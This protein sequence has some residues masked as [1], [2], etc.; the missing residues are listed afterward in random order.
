[1][2]K[3]ERLKRGDKVAV[4]SLS[5][6]GLGDKE[7]I[8]KYY[9]AK[10]R[11]KNIFGLELIPT[12]NA[13]KGTEFIYNH[14][15]LRAKDWMDAFRDPSIK[16]IFSAIGGDD[17]I[18]LLPFIDYDVIRNN[19]KI[20]SG[21]SDTTANHFMMYKAGVTSFYGPCILSDF[22]QYGSMF[23]YTVDAINNVF[24]DANP[25]FEVA[26]VGVN[27]CP[28][29]SNKRNEISAVNNLYKELGNTYDF[30]HFVDVEYL[31]CD[32]NKN[33]LNKYFTDGL[34]PNHEGYKMAAQ[35]IKEALN[36]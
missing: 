10:E 29:A 17:T 20:F 21:F 33:E 24:F 19:P 32:S 30:I 31:Y 23:D 6:G 35:L 13:L 14:P 15:E 27:R 18:R 26:L 36:K 1:M 5:W 2:I 8:H 7:I 9:L 12:P 28:F 25:N 4:V 3:P 22:A 34:H 11:L 16:A